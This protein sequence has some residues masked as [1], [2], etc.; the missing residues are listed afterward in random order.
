MPLD[1]APGNEE[2]NQPANDLGLEAVMRHSH[3]APP[4]HGMTPSHDP[5]NAPISLFPR[6]L[7]FIQTLLARV[8][9]PTG[10]IICDM[11]AWVPDLEESAHRTGVGRRDGTISRL[12][13]RDARSINWN[14]SSPAVPYILPAPSSPLTPVR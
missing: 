5:G 4:A 3:R 2:E 9:T 13:C 7:A 8:D 6:I 14:E 11:A 1:P 12:H 10:G